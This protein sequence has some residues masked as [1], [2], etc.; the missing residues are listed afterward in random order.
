MEGRPKHTRPLARTLAGARTGPVGSVSRRW[1]PS[2][3]YSRGMVALHE[4][5]DWLLSTIALVLVVLFVAV[6]ALY[7]RSGRGDHDR[8]AGLLRDDRQDEDGR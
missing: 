6:L 2:Q 4:S 7:L 3:E 5:T 1:G 8:Y